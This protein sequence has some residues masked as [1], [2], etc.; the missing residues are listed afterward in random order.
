MSIVFG[1]ISMGESSE[2]TGPTWA[3]VLAKFPLSTRREWATFSTDGLVHIALA[4]DPH[5]QVRRSL[6]TNPAISENVREAL[7]R[8]PDAQV[9]DSA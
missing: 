7:R 6:V 2:R 4:Q 8:D 3:E 5:P 1:G 9:R